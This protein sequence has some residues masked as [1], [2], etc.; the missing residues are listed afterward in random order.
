[1]D[2]GSAFSDALAAHE[3]LVGSH[4]IRIVRAG[5]RNGALPDALRIAAEH[6]EAERALARRIWAVGIYSGSMLAIAIIVVGWLSY[7]YIHAVA[8]SASSVTA[9]LLGTIVALAG[10]ACLGLISIYETDQEIRSAA[11]ARSL[12]ALLRA[13][14]LMAPDELTAHAEGGSAFLREA[15]ALG[16]E[17]GTAGEMLRHAADYHESAMARQAG[18]IR[19]ALQAIVFV[20]I[21]AGVGIAIISAFSLQ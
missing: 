20:A 9:A 13:G 11:V 12:S 15:L 4:L 10:I 6:I 3:G 21:G 5:E 16:I 1:M 17:T 19:T 14:E 2:N 7:L 18:G 8:G